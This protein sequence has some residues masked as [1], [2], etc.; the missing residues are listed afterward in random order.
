MICVA[1]SGYKSCIGEVIK[2]QEDTKEQD[3]T[4]TAVLDN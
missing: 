3:S 1:M 4:A 2:I